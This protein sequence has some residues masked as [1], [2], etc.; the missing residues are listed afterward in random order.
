MSESLSE[1]LSL[2]M[3]YTARLIFLYGAMMLLSVRLS[4]FTVLG[5]P[6]IWIVPEFSGRFYQVG[7]VF[8]SDNKESQKKRHVSVTSSS[9]NL[10]Y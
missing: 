6:I 8:F 7:S 1:E 4:V 10:L 5:L 3:W 2:L 9:C